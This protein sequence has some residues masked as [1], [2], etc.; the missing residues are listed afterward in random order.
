MMIM[1]RLKNGV[2]AQISAP[3]RDSLW[4]LRTRGDFSALSVVV[5]NQLQLSYG[6]GEDRSH[7]RATMEWLCAAQ[8]ATDDDG[9]SAFYDM[10]EGRWAPSYPETTGY[11][12]PTFLEYAAYAKDEEYVER[13]RRMANWL[14]SIQL[15]SG[16]MPIGPLWPDWE[17]KPI[18]FDTG[19]V[20][21]GLISVFEQTGDARYLDGARRAGD[22]LVSTQDDDGCWRRY[23]SLG[24]VH[25]FN[26]RVA[27]ALIRLGVACE[28]DEY[29]GAGERNLAWAVA[30]QTTD[31][32]FRDNG[33]TP[34]EDPLTHTIAYTIRGML[35]SGNLVGDTPSVAAARLAADVLC[36]RQMEDGY[37]RA[38]YGPGWRSEAEWS[39]LTGTAQMAIVWMRLHEMD[40]GDHY[41][42][43]ATAAVAYLKRSQSRNMRRTGVGGG[44]AGSFPVF[45]TYE[46]YRYLNWAAKF[47]ADSLLLKERLSGSDLGAASAAPHENDLLG[48]D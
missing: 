2:R 16:G 20:I 45:Q 13:A 10:R 32:W 33:F 15:P 1:D 6:I 31:G 26:V 12:I 25:T 37:L 17:R 24:H 46:P 39:C 29:L 38:S 4:V 42:D 27:W 8:D 9:V 36:E 47:F 48:R 23:T 28:G 40:G 43:A 22:W 30:Q 41:L 21:H 5:R 7:L 35:E 3:I 44:I 11:I 18:V 34:D 19:Q 14:L